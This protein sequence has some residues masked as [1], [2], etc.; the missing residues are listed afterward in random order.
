MSATTFKLNAAEF[1]LNKITNLKKTWKTITHLKARF[2]VDVA[3][4][5]FLCEIMSAVDSLLHDVNDGL[6]LGIATDE[7]KLRRVQVEM[8]LAGFNV[9]DLGDLNNLYSKGH[10]LCDLRKL[11]NYSVHQR[12]LGMAITLELPAGTTKVYLPKPWIS[13]GKTKKEVIPYFSD[14]LRNVRNLV[15][16]VKKRLQLS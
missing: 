2:K 3:V 15:K 5:G 13:G 6:K 8:C 1:H 16:D 11:R 7:V 10:W 12:L 9:A 4:D 14:Q